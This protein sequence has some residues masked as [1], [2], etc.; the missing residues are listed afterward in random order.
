LKDVPVIA[1]ETDGA[2][3]FAEAVKKGELVT[4]PAVTSIAKTLGAKRV[5]QEALDWTK[6]HKVT[7]VI[8]SDRQAVDACLKFADDHRC[9]VEQACGAGNLV[10]KWLLVISHSKVWLWGIRS[11]T[12]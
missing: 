5:C 12:S 9:L 2:R 7:S 6:K 1:C 3:S 10:M 4:I 8:C 11:L